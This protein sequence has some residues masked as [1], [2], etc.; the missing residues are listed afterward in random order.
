[1]WSVLSVPLLLLIPVSVLCTDCPK[2]CQCRSDSIFCASRRAPTMPLVPQY[3]RKLY[4]FQNGILLL[5]QEDFAGMDKLEMVDLSQN[6]LSELPDRV[7]QSMSSLR[8]LDLSGNKITHVSQH[9]FFGLVQLERLYLYSNQIQTIHPDA[10]SSLIHLLELKLQGN[11]LTSLP[12]LRMPKLVLL[13]LS[14]NHLP[15]PGPEDLQMP[16]LESLKLAGMGLRTVNE[17][18]LGNLVNLHEL[19]LSSNQ[20]TAFPQVLHRARGLIRL[21]LAGN[22]LGPLQAKDLKPLTELQEL[23]ISNLSLQG[24]PEGFADLLNL[25][26]LTL[27]E[28]PFNCLCSLGWF[29]TWLRAKQIT[30]DRTE[31]TRC[32]F[33]PLNAGKVLERLERRDFGCPPT[34]T[35]TV[36][37]LKTTTA[38]LTAATTHSTV[39][40]TAPKP[41]IPKP[42]QGSEPNGKD[43]PRHPLPSL[44]TLKPRTVPP[45]LCPSKICL[46][47]GTCWID[48]Q[49]Q[50][51]C[52]CPPQSSGTY[53]ENTEELDPVSSATVIMSKTSDISPGSVTSTTIQLDLHR[54]IE[55]RPFIQGIRLTYQNLS[56]PDRRPLQLNLPAT[57]KEYTLRGL[58][59]NCTYYVCASP[60]GEAVGRDSSCTQAHTNWHVHPNNTADAR[61]TPPSTA[62]L[63]PAVALLLLLVLI[64]TAMGVACHLHRKR[65]EGHLQLDTPEQE[66]DGVKVGLDSAATFS[67]QAEIGDSVQNGGLEHEIPLMQETANNNTAT[68]KP[69][70]C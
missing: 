12:A 70:Y 11:Q 51:G 34:T 13:D 28:N 49:G 14:F 9:S 10:F 48:Q 60:L 25:R 30:L 23:D 26:K 66:L 3:T 69:S 63:G 36:R 59:P 1:M 29:P 4:V 46:N 2:D 47:G 32:H 16:S 54:Y 61:I 7:F 17:E 24:L 41:R 6:Q 53:C 45:E 8:N 50:L 58:R 31:E 56:G 38:Q 27:A 64:A 62:M 33:P 67:K 5:K 18:L 22:Q 20:L 40:P 19:N 43:G 21:S 52:T 15:P 44:T 57:Y 37:P 55:T 39:A 68:L 35:V 65:A 42:G